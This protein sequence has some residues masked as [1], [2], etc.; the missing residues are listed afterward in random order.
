MEPGEIIEIENFVFFYGTGRFFL[1]LNQSS[2]EKGRPMINPLK[3]ITHP[4][5]TAPGYTAGHD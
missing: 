3:S 4:C 2:G 1:R 5:N